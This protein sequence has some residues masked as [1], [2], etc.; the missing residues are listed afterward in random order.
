MEKLVWNDNSF[1]LAG[2]SNPYPWASRTLLSCQMPDSISGNVYESYHLGMQQQSDIIGNQ[3]IQSSVIAHQYPLHQ[4]NQMTGQLVIPSSMDKTAADSLHTSS[5]SVRGWGYASPTEIPD[6]STAATDM[7][8]SKHEMNQN[9]CGSFDQAGPSSCNDL[10]QLCYTYDANQLLSL[11][12]TIESLDSVLSSDNGGI[13]AT[14]TT[15]DNMKPMVLSAQ[16]PPQKSTSSIMTYSV[17]RHSNS[18]EK[19]QSNSHSQGSSDPITMKSKAMNCKPKSKT[20]PKSKAKGKTHEA[21]PQLGTHYNY[22]SSTSS[23]SCLVFG[24]ADPAGIEPDAEAIASVREMIYRAAAFRPVNLGTEVLDK[25]MK[26][27]NIKISSV[28]Q[29]VSARE[30]RERISDKIRILQRLVPGA[31]KMDTASMLEEAANYLKFLKA[32]VNALQSM[33]TGNN[34]DS[35]NSMAGLCFSTSNSLNSFSF[36]TALNSQNLSERYAVNKTT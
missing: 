35:I 11:Q 18:N 12:S 2:E 16:N 24:Q 8:I 32:Q 34:K 31:T 33:G 25:P 1:I 15:E 14:S 23:S 26:R 5:R 9:Y 30:R 36:N 28:P 3:L 6:S 27:K 20:K 21:N 19:N 17:Q 22:S 29:T 10:M 4:T 13:S 7:F